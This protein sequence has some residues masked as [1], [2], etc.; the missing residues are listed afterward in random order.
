MDAA[1]ALAVKAK[2]FRGLD[3][4]PGAFC[5]EALCAGVA[6]ILLDP[7]SWGSTIEPATVAVV[8]IVADELPKAEER[9]RLATN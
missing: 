7:A 4:S 3:A 8:G 5:I 2:A 9:L 1:S 6:G